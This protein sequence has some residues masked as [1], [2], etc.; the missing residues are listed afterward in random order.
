[1]LTPAEEHIFINFIIDNARRGSPLTHRLL[2]QKANALLRVRKGLF[3]EVGKAWVSR[4][5]AIHSKELS[6][7]YSNPLDRSRAS[8]LNPVAVGMYFDTLEALERNHDIPTE[9]WYGTDESGFSLGLNGTREVIGPAGQKI[10][11]RQQ[12]GEWEI[13]TVLEIIC[14]DGTCLKPTVIFK[15]K[16]LL[17]KWGRENPCDTK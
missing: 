15:G 6:T 13:V 7:Y 8:G 2:R 16:N 10:Q 5:L 14:T 9:N 1:M 3:F 17:T 12:D 11:H 4:F